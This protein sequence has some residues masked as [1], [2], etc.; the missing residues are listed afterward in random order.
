MLDVLEN[1]M[2]KYID[3]ANTE[4]NAKTDNV[5]INVGIKDKILECISNHPHISIPQIARFLNVNP[6]TVERYMKELREETKIIREGSKKS[7][8]WKITEN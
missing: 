1:T 6:R 4:T 2:Y 8:Q 7:G 3:T 5:G